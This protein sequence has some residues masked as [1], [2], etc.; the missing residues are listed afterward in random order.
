MRRWYSIPRLIR[1]E[2]PEEPRP[3][4]PLLEEKRR[5]V[6]IGILLLWAKLL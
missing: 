3:D 2:R 6:C 1:Y 5:E 4:T